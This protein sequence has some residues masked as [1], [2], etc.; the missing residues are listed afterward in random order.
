MYWNL[1]LNRI[2]RLTA[3]RVVDLHQYNSLEDRSNNQD[4]QH[5][6]VSADVIERFIIHLP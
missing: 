1:G 5:G 2:L 3:L 6:H 4:L